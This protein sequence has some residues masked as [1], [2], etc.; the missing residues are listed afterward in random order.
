MLSRPLL[1]LRTA[2]VLNKR[3]LWLSII[4]ASNLLNSRPT[5]LVEAFG[6]VARMGTRL[7]VQEINLLQGQVGG[8]GVA[9]VDERYEGE[10]CAHEDE[11]RFPLE[12]TGDYWGDHDDEEV[13]VDVTY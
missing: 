2:V 5:L 12:P 13:L 9:E 6:D 1:H 7:G 8:F 4:A 11:V 10:V 3:G